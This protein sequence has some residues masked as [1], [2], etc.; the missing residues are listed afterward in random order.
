MFAKKTVTSVLTAFNKALDDLKLV[1]REAELEAARQAQIIEE[2]RAAHDAA[3]NE[4]VLARDVASKLV[5][6]ATPNVTNMTVA[7]L[8]Q[9]CA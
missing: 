3:V 1:E 9:E 8:A 5:D 6:L 7:E 2:A 4:A